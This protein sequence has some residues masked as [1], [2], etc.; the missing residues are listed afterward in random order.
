MP[1][2]R[3]RPTWPRRSA[4][5]IKRVDAG[6]AV[7]G[8]AP[9]AASCKEIAAAYRP[10]LLDDWLDPAMVARGQAGQG[11]PGAPRRARARRAVR[12]VGPAAGGALGP[13]RARAPGV[14]R[15][16]RGPDQGRDLAEAA[17]GRGAARPGRAERGAGAGDLRG[18]AGRRDAGRPPRRRAAPRP[19]RDG[20]P[21]SQGARRRSPRLP[22]GEDEAADRALLKAW[23][24]G[25]DDLDRLHRSRRVPRPRRGG[26]GTDRRASIELKR[27]IEEADQGRGPEQAVVDAAKALP[28]RYGA[29]FADR[30]RQA[31]ERLVSSAALDQ[32]LAASPPSDLAIAAAAERA[33]AGGTWPTEAAVAAR[34][35]LAIRRRDL[36]RTLDA[37]PASLPLDE[38]DAR[39]AAAWDDALLADCHDARQHRVRH[40]AA[41][42]RIAAFA[43]LERA[44][45]KGDAIT[46]K[47][48]ARDPILADHPGLVR[49]RA[50]IEALIA[51]S[52]QVER[53][54]AAA[55]GGQ[56][57]AFL[58]EAEPSLL[59]AHAAEFTPYR[60]RIASWVDA[61]LAAGRHPPPGRPDVPPRRRAGR[62]SPRAGPGGSRGSCEPAWSPPTRTR[63]LDRPEEAVREPSTSTRT[64]TARK[65]GTAFALPPGC[66]K[67]YVTVWPV[68]DFGWDRRVGPPFRH[69]ALCRR[70]GRSSPIGRSPD[71][72]IEATTV[73]QRL[74]TWFEQLL[75]W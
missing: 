39:W 9:R 32:A 56:A 74:R 49:Q 2:R 21:A 64:P 62:P 38:Q 24:A 22:T 40:A 7:R 72:S 41:I 59:A 14:R 17:R 35:E 25:R 73:V 30:I 63:F 67:L 44:L 48:L 33:R 1:P 60:D 58:A 26:Q 37:I 55:Q 54:V 43:E 65:G 46:V 27:R 15:G 28:P 8:E 52:E 20:R 36:L 10:E 23:G 5:P 66:R 42:A 29:S 19:R 12:P 71:G 51:K 13:A 68:V 11:G 75:N 31:R 47:R 3:S 70:R 57:E 16:G 45:E 18:L 6:P 4:R 69:R 61:R 34:C 53:L 50:E